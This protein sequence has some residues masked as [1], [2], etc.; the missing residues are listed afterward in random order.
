MHT[1]LSHLHD[2]AC[3]HGSTA[4][5]ASLAMDIHTVVGCP[6]YL[7]YPDTLYE[8]CHCGWL[9]VNSREPVLINTNGSPLLD[10]LKGLVGTW[11]Y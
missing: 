2:V 9:V 10:P 3:N 11:W 8:V 5:L 4:T 7:C 6:C 1:V